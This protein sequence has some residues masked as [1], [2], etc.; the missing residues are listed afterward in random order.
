MNVVVRK[1]RD[2]FH[3]IKTVERMVLYEGCQDD[4]VD[5]LKV[6]FENINNKD[7]VKDA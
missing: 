2:L 6:W 4:D 3:K 5:A 7:R 1:L